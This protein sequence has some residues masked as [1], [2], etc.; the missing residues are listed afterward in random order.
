MTKLKLNIQLF[1][2]T[3]YDTSAAEIYSQNSTGSGGYRHRVILYYYWHID[4]STRKYTLYARNRFYHATSTDNWVNGS[5]YN[6]LLMDGTEKCKTTNNL[7][8][9]SSGG[10]MDLCPS[11]N[12]SSWQNMG[13]YDYSDMGK[14]SAHSVGISCGYASSWAGISSKTTTHSLT[15]PDIDPANNVLNSVANFNI[16]DGFTPNITSY[17]LNSYMSIGS[18]T[19]GYDYAVSNGTS[20]KLTD[21][22]KNTIITLL[23]ATNSV[24]LNFTLQTKNGDTQ[25]GTSGPVQATCTVP[26]TTFTVE[27]DANTQGKYNFT[28]DNHGLYDTVTVLYGN[29]TIIPEA[30]YS[31]LTNSI[32]LTAAQLTTVYGYMPSTSENLT[33]RFK[34]Y[35]NSTK[36]Y[37]YNTVDKSANITM[38][39][40]SPT[41]TALTYSDN[42]STYNSKKANATDIIAGL[43]K[44]NITVTLSNNYNNTYTNA[45]CN[46]ATG[47]INNTNR[48]ATFTNLN[49]ANSYKIKITDSRGKSPEYTYNGAAYTDTIKTVPWFAP[50]ITSITITRPDGPLGA[51]AQATVVGTYYAGANLANLSNASLQVEYSYD[52]TNYTAFSN[53]PATSTNGSFNTTFELSGDSEFYKKPIF[54]RAK[55]TDR[56][57]IAMSNWSN[58]NIPSGQPVFNTFRDSVG[59]NHFRANGGLTAQTPQFLYNCVSTNNVSTGTYIKL[60]HITC[61]SHYQ[62]R[63]VTFRV[64]LGYGNNGNTTQNAYIDLYLQQGY[65]GS[66]NGRFGGNWI[67]NPMFSNLKLNMVNIIVTSDSRLEYDVWLYTTA[68]YCVPNYAFDC[69]EGIKIIHD[70]QTKQTTLPAGT[71]TSCNVAGQHIALSSMPV[72]HIYMSVD[73]TSPATLFGGGWSQLTNRFLVGAGGSYAVNTTGGGTSTSYT[74]AGTV[75]NHTLTESEIPAHT[76]GSKSLS[77]S[78]QNGNARFPG[79][80]SVSGIV[81]NIKKSINGYWSETGGTDT[82]TVGFN[83]DATHEHNSFG[84][85]N[86]QHNHGFTGTAATISTMPPY[87]AVYMWQRTS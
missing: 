84:G 59:D 83:I 67:L 22:H 56:I 53:S 52:G 15:P 86:P 82:N 32:T 58:A 69:D 12:G 72:G 70:G 78:W 35:K 38:P 61:Q 71:D 64:Y 66:E 36:N 50:S 77:G 9:H 5:P 21:T 75:A 4:P 47:T 79:T 33:F 49:Q 55:I 63:F 62:G 3:P 7:G 46:G 16:D 87:L 81:T 85:S 42:V 24:I 13:T 17:G 74:P 39:N 43:S 1:A 8:S 48:T 34:T 23:G 31:S 51:R 45:T 41:I 25:V 20:C 65:T 76:H 28:R 10:T 6:R 14:G 30:E 37:I 73:S 54:V 26:V 27:K 19:S 40:Y 80:S 18:V 44:P 29:N 57:G 60:C 68:T 11:F 2:L